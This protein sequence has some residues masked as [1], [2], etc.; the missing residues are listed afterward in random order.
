MNYRNDIKNRIFNKMNNTYNKSTK[1]NNSNKLHNVTSNNVFS[2]VTVTNNEYYEDLYNLFE[3]KTIKGDLDIDGDLETL[4][5]VTIDGKLHTKELF[6]NNT[7]ILSL[8]DKK[9]NDFEININKKI[10][11]INIRLNTIEKK[12]QI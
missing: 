12:I 8:I 3:E 10:T 4:G 11:E 9:I 6:I 7:N 1:S 2:N 5:D